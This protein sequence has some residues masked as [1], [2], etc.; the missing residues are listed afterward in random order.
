[1]IANG[2]SLGK[3]TVTVSE[4]KAQTPAFTPP[5]VVRPDT[6]PAAPAGP[7]TSTLVAAL[8]AYKSAFANASGKNKKDC[9]SALSGP[10]G[11]KLKGWETWCDEAKSF[12][13]SEQSCSA[14]GSPEAPTLNC[15]ETLTIRLKDG[16][17]Q[18]SSSQKTFRFAKGSD[19]NWQISSF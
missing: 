8:G 6:K 3:Q 11:G 14:G 17:P 10:F 7:D 5:V 1:L 12:D 9:Q 16:D 18:K 4:P 19:G 15:A 13:L 2:T